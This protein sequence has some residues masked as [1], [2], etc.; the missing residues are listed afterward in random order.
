MKYYCSTAEY[1]KLKPSLSQGN[2]RSA[3]PYSL[4]ALHP[5]C[6]GASL[7]HARADSGEADREAGADG[8]ERRDPHGATLSRCWSVGFRVYK[9]WG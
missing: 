1:L 8:G 7:T 6:F 4:Y 5:E 2:G 9:V 3:T